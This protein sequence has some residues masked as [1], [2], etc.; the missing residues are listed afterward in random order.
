MATFGQLLARQR[1]KQA[2]QATLGRT[3]L[4]TDVQTEQKQLEAGRREYQAEVEKAE[5]EMKKRAKK[6]G[7]R[8][9][10][11]QIVG[12]T[13]GLATGQPLLG[14]AVT[15]G[16]SGVGAALVPEYETTIK[17]LVPEGK[18]FSEARADFDADI[19]STNRFIKDAAEGQNL[20]DLTNALTDAYTSFTMTKT[21]GKDFDKM[22]TKAAKRFQ[23]K[24]TFLE[25]TLGNI[26]NKGETL[27]LFKEGTF[28]DFLAKGAQ[29]RID[30]RDAFKGQ[31]FKMMSNII[32]KDKE[33]YEPFKIE[34][35]LD[36]PT[37]NILDYFRQRRNNRN[38]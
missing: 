16:V 29:E 18:F 13:V 2:L 32:N 21:F 11:G 28:G 30:A 15:G 3:K 25:R 23:D 20:L 38:N 10:L 33:D 34:E 26:F 37:L 9:L 17:N 27:E 4:Q 22:L 19:A 8:R 14:A 7:R 35:T 12:T 5:R 6:R 31:S 24:N 36:L 1:G